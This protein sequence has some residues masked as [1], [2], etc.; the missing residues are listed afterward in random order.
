[1]RLED[2]GCRGVGGGEDLP[3]AASDAQRL[4]ILEV[5]LCALP[6]T[7]LTLKS[8]SVFRGNRDSSPLIVESISGTGSMRFARPSRNVE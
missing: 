6:W 5:E 4:V 7:N 3:S 8:V 2:S 1:M